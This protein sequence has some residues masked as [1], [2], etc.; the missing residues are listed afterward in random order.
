M[1]DELYNIRD[2]ADGES[3][4]DIFL[5]NTTAAWQEGIIRATY[6][7]QLIVGQIPAVKEE[8]AALREQVA[9][10]QAQ[11]A[12][13]RGLLKRLE[14]IEFGAADLCVICGNEPDKHAPDCALAAALAQLPPPAQEE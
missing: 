1:S 5:E 3:V 13:A 11:V 7:G 14:W 8:V 12:A 4:I 6:G 10:L 9:Q 2:A